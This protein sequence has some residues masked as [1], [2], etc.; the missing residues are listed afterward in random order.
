MSYS[1]DGQPKKLWLHLH[2]LESDLILCTKELM[3][4]R[5][6]LHKFRCPDYLL[7]CLLYRMYLFTRLIAIEFLSLSANVRLF[8]FTGF[9]QL[10]IDGLSS[11]IEHDLLLCSK[12]ILVWDSPML[13]FLFIHHLFSKSLCSHYMPSHSTK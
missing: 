9:Q 2:L 1:K 5:K 10:L 3:D 7:W 6:W 11:H 4:F 12:A 8:D 13:R